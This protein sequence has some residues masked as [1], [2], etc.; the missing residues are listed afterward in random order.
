MPPV[1]LPLDYSLDAQLAALVARPDE[2]LPWNKDGRGTGYTPGVAASSGLPVPAS[3]PLAL[4][5][6][7]TGS[8]ALAGA[9]GS[10]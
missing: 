3:V 10:A 2:V 9:P 4:A 5:P 6:S 7:D 1:I 8:V